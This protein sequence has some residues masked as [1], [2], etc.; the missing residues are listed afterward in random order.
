MKI[1]LIIACAALLAAPFVSAQPKPPEVTPLSLPDAETHTVTETDGDPVLIHIV[2]PKDW[3]PTDRRPGFMWFFG[4][5]FV[6]GTPDKSIGWARSAARKGMVGIAPDYRTVSRWPGVDARAGLAD[7]RAAL[8]WVQDHADELGIDPEKIVVGGGSAGG[9]VA[10][11][12]AITDSPPGLVPDLPPLHKP[13]ALILS[14]PAS[15]VSKATGMRGNRFGKLDTDAYS[16]LQHLDKVMP[17][18]FL[19]HGDA[20]TVVPYAHSVALHAA[21]TANGNVCEF[22]TVPGGT[23][24]ISQ[25]MPEWKKK[26]PQLHQAFLENLGLLPV[27][28]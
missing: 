18:T 1:P 21:L 28:P 3:K 15:D 25:E 16:P 13:A 20:D 24:K 19:L 9:G 17:P 27:K 4:G 10:L 6:R 2:K 11:W 8:R 22:V 23:H 7:A 12:T 14:F 5:G 26:I